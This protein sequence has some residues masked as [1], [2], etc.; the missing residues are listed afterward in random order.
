MLAVMKLHNFAGDD[1]LQSFVAVRQVRERVLLTGEA[2]RGPSCLSGTP[3]QRPSGQHSL[4]QWL[5]VM[6]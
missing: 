2:A 3:K 5:V 6:N 4:L 1:R